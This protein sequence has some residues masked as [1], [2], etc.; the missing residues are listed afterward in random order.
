MG[1]HIL[2]RRNRALHIRK[3]H[4]GLPS[5]L[6]EEGWV[7]ACTLRCGHVT[8]LPLLWISLLL[9]WSSHFSLI[10]LAFHKSEHFRGEKDD[11]SPQ[12]R[13]VKVSTQAHHGSYS[14]RSIL[15]RLEGDS[16]TFCL[17]SICLWRIRSHYDIFQTKFL[18]VVVVSP[19]PPVCPP[20]QQSVSHFHVAATFVPTPSE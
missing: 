14:E 9:A 15:S 1:T 8:L 6:P 2:R 20:P 7:R 5:S 17:F 11:P 4:W 12:H 10:W 18:V 3:C 13:S 16:H 19:L